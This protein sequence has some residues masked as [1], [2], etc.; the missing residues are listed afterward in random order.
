MAKR[1][2]EHAVCDMWLTNVLGVLIIL[3]E[4]LF[5]DV[6]YNFRQYANASTVPPIKRITAIKSYNNPSFQIS[7]HYI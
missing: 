4:K 3:K 6:R 5:G 7:S 2:P 1:S